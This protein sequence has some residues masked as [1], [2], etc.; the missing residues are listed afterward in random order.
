MRILFCFISF[1]VLQICYC[2][3][4][5]SFNNIQLIYPSTTIEAKKEINN[6]LRLNPHENEY[7]KSI[8]DSNYI[9][10]TAKQYLPID[11]YIKNY[12]NKKNNKE[13]LN[14]KI[15]WFLKYYNIE[16]LFNKW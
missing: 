16:K 2:Q 14:F 11:N 8:V 15:N 3:E 4:L 9:F 12:D 5:T 13:F 10:L 6:Y 7:L 1:F